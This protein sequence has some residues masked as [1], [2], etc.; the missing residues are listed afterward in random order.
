MCKEERLN[1]LTS[2]TAKNSNPYASS[3][4]TSRNRNATPI[5]KLCPDKSSLSEAFYSQA[6]QHY[7]LGSFVKL[8][9]TDGSKVKNISHPFM[10]EFV[11]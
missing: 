11:S 3:T 2:S 9:P 5:S 4:T 6:P 7:P 10:N 1:S 8:E